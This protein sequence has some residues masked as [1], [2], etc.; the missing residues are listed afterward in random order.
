MT[1]HRLEDIEDI[2]III[3]DEWQE[4]PTPPPFR[5]LVVEATPPPPPPPRAESAPRPDPQPAPPPPPRADAGPAVVAPDFDAIPPLPL[6]R[7]F[8]DRWEEL[9]AADRV[10]HL[11]ATRSGPCV[12]PPE[13]L[14]AIPR[15]TRLPIDELRTYCADY[16]WPERSLVV[17][18]RRLGVADG[19]HHVT[20]A[21]IHPPRL[22]GWRGRGVPREATSGHD[23]GEPTS[24]GGGLDQ[25]TVIAELLKQ[26]RAST[27]GGMIEETLSDPALFAERLEMA[28]GV[29]E[30]AA[31]W[32]DKLLDVAIPR[33][34]QRWD[35]A[36]ARPEAPPEVGPERE[37]FRRWREEHKGG[38]K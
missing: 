21:T 29:G 10:V 37:G 4:P 36:G 33:L 26:H 25:I 17:V 31:L 30:V 3:D 22:G 12:V 28:K 9:D 20:S 15:A 23:D 16:G 6:P 27:L 18:L 14:L 19:Q 11:R 13:D 24:G 38:A 8:L 32:A 7:D 35:D 34:R 5:A 2:E 1:I